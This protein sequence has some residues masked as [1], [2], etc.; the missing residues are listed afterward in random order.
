MHGWK[1]Y[2]DKYGGGYADKY[3]NK[4]EGSGNPGSVPGNQIGGD[5]SNS[6]QQQT[7][8]FCKCL[9][10][11]KKSGKSYADSQNDFSKCMDKADGNDAQHWERI[12]RKYAKKFDSKD[13]KWGDL[14]DITSTPQPW[15]QF[16]STAVAAAI[17]IAE[18]DESEDAAFY[19]TFIGSGVLLFV[20]LWFA[21]IGN[22]PPSLFA[23]GLNTCITPPTNRAPPYIYFRKNR[24]ISIFS[25]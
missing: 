7:D 3:E 15:P 25:K 23:T 24:Q 6:D 18:N 14:P 22:R 1:K 4:Y 5:D 20:C 21:K 17:L 2:E 8:T 10:D 11:E 12:A 16:K 13:H 9:A 19:V